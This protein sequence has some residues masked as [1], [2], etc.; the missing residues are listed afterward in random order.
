M[1]AT[2]EVAFFDV[3]KKK[4]KKRKS[5]ESS[6]NAGEDS[7]LQEGD[8]GDKKKGTGFLGDTRASKAVADAVSS[9]DVDNNSCRRKKKKDRS[10][11]EEKEK[12]INGD[13]KDKGSD[14]KGEKKKK[15]QTGDYG[16]VLEESQMMEPKRKDKSDFELAKEKNA[17]A[18]EEGEVK[19][20]KHK[21]KKEHKRK[22]LVYAGEN[23]GVGHDGSVESQVDNE[24]KENVEPVPNK[25]RKKKKGEKDLGVDLVHDSDVHSINREDGRG[26]SGSKKKKERSRSSNTEGDVNTE[27]QTDNEVTKRVYSKEDKKTKKK[28]D[29]GAGCTPTNEENSRGGGSKKKGKPNGSN[30]TEKDADAGASKTKKR[31]R[32]TETSEKSTSR[33]KLKRVRFSDQDEVFSL[34]D[35]DSSKGE[36]AR[37]ARHTSADGLVRGKRFSEEEDEIV[38]N[39]VL[40]YIESHQL[41]EEGIQMVMKCSNHPEIRDCWKV[42]GESLPWRPYSS[43]YYRAHIL[44]ER[45]EKRKWSEEELE[46]VRKYHEEHGANWKQLADELGKH[47][48]HVK[49]A[50]RRIKLPNRKNG[51]WSQ[52]EYQSLFDLVNVDLSLKLFE[53]KKSKHGMLRDN[54]SWEAISGKL[55][56]RSVPICCMKWYQQLTSPLVAEGK[57]ADADDYRL[58][59]ALV[60]VDAPCEDEVDWDNLLEHRSGEICRKRWS[61]MVRHIGEPGVKQF[62]EQ[63]DILSK[64]YCAD[65]LE[66]RETFDNKP[67][68]D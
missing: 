22:E 61:Q 19:K 15:S 25:K 60:E 57:W 18:R 65:L 7:T 41:G 16:G 56:T 30:N 34:P 26:D 66:A 63:V 37:E 55:T 40:D 14:H 5:R 20:K 1:D 3:A 36:K 10:R 35:N 64:R 13:M 4:S 31:K 12:D 44:F 68:V 9:V 58:L 11:K 23:D 45:G 51:H 42:I 50:W 28:K 21:S 6:D 24:L 46:L 47:R 62:N 32:A 59:I 8:K 2:R 52:E 17:R 49:D 54:I 27:N 29:K 53:E 39:A 43:V 38:K 33:K 48:I 67:Y